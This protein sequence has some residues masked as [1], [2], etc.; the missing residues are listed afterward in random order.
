MLNP[1]SEPK[2]EDDKSEAEI[3]MSMVTGLKETISTMLDK[4]DQLQGQE[5]KH[6]DSLRRGLKRIKDERASSDVEP[7]IPRQ[8]LPIDDVLVKL[9]GSDSADKSGAPCC[10]CNYCLKCIFMWK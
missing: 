3:V 1:S 7:M 2:S 6:Y 5:K 9:S 8:S 4:V 10:I